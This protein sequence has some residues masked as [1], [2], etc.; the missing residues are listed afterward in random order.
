M[1]LDDVIQNLTASDIEALEIW[2]PFNGVDISP[3]T[4]P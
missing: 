4:T 1:S 3:N 2:E